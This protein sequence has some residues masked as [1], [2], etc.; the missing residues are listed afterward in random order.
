MENGEFFKIFKIIHYLKNRKGRDEHF[1]YKIEVGKLRCGIAYKSIPPIAE[2]GSYN[3]S[4]HLHL[5]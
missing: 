2:I 4:K 5:T 1:H 3:T